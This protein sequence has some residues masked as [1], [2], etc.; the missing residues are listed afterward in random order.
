M[1]EITLA[2]CKDCLED[3]DTVDMVWL[4]GYTCIPCYFSAVAGDVYE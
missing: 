4:K 3:F 1:S 2:T